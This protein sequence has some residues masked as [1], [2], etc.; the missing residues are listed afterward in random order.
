[1][2]LSI[3]LVLSGISALLVTWGA[4]AFQGLAWLW[5]FP[6]SFA[7][8]FLSVLLLIFL[9]ICLMSLCVNMKRPQENDNGFYRAVIH[10]VVDLLLPIL[11]IRIHT[12]GLEKVPKSGRVFLVCNHLNDIDPVVLL[13]CFPKQQLAFISKKENDKKPI[14]GPFLHRILCQ[15][16]NRENDRDALKTILNC[17]RLIKENKVS[18]GVFPEG[19]VSKDGMLHTFRSGVFKIAQKTGIPILVCTLQNTQFA[20]ANARHLKPTDIH[21]HLVGVLQPEELQG[22]TTIDVG[23]RVHAMMAQDLGPDLVLQE[24]N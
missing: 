19:Y 21:L 7:G 11:R 4:D 16:V 22:M 20:L 14:I 15:S 12:Q 18:I 1:M 3:I 5:V 17:I 13:H 8:S 10:F 9:L 2:T 23:N 24:E 6:V